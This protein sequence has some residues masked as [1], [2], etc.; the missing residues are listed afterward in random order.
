VTTTSTHSQQPAAAAGTAVDEQVRIRGPLRRLLLTLI[1]TN[2][3]LFVAYGAVP[4]VMLAVQ[5]DRIDPA[6]KVA[7][8]ALITTV[9]AFAAM[10]AQPVA[11]AISD[12]TRSRFGRRA[13]W[14]VLG[15]VVGGLS[16]VGIAMA[17]GIAQIAIAFALMQ[18]AYNFA[19]GP[20]SAVMPDRV[21]AGALGRFAALSGMSAMLGA[22]GGQAVGAAFSAHLSAGYLVLAGV[23]I[24]ML[25]SF[26]L[27]NP[28]RSS[29]DEQRVPFRAADFL[30]TFWVSP[31]AY[32]DFAWAFLGRLLL[33][34]GYFAVM[35]YNLYLLQDY[36]GLGDG[37]VKYVPVLGLLGLVGMI[38]AI[39]VAG[40]LSDRAGRR[41]R[42]VF[43]S[44]VLVGIGLAI[45]ILSPTLPGL[46]VQAVVCGLG[47]G[48]FQAVDQALMT[49]VLPSADS[50]AKD[51]GVVNIAATLPQVLA[52]AIGGAVVLAFGY[53]GIFP[54]GIALSLLGA[55]AVFFIRSV[56]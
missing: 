49:Q 50:Y 29:V 24:V 20:L 43:A 41:K 53:V 7:H 47:F 26:V 23:A 10:I 52:P 12:R 31:K 48:A 44:S 42:F 22:I 40:P 35:G 36:V 55:F 17:H 39:L 27:L 9:G 37:A 38:P 16:L 32:P 3:A 56:R 46:M 54:V 2:L 1:P 8:L 19:Q 15:A 4:G 33:Y 34:A 28:D 25:T 11:G 30:R 18:V 21:P 13:P 5:V 14:I 51:L 45:P 6:H